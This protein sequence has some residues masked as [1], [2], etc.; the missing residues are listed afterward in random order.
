[1]TREY[2]VPF[3][4]VEV[5]SG[6]TGGASLGQNGIVCQTGHLK[7]QYCMTNAARF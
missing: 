4:A 5:E 6:G 3:G 2:N 7:G 1:M